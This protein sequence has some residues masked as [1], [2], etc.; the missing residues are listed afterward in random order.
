[1]DTDVEVLKPL[2]AFLHH[3][4]F[5][6]FEDD[7][8]IPTGIMGAE[9]GS[10]WAKENLAYY[11]GRHFIMEDGRMDVTTNVVTLTNYMLPLGLKQD[12]TF[13]NFPGVITFY[14][15]DYF[16]PKSHVD[17][18]LYLTNNSHTIHHFSGSW[19]PSYRRKW[20]SILLRIGGVRL[21][22]LIKGIYGKYK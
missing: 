4:A 5:S 22:N 12:N 8:N 15:K 16:C 18:K 6:G 21:K 9:K 11:E 20:R 17:E 10:M 7:H 3:V 1:M 13:Q 14:P 19:I 2:D